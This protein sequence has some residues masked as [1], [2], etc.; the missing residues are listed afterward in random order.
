MKQMLFVVLCIVSSTVYSQER[1]QEDIE[2]EKA[3]QE[4]AAKLQQDSA[5]SFGWRTRWSQE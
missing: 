2:R 1:S 4:R 5:K 3:F